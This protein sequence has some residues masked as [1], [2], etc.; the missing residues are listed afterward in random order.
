LYNSPTCKDIYDTKVPYDPEGKRKELSI[1]FNIL[2]LGLLG[3]LSGTLLC[4]LGVQAGHSF[5]YSTRVRRVCT[6]W[7]VS[8]LI[9]GFLGLLLSKGGH[10]ESWIPINK[11]MWSLS[12]I[13]ILSSLA[14][15]IL[16][17]L[18]LLVDVRKIFTG[19]PWIWLGMNSIVVFCGHEICGGRFP[20]EFQVN[21][22]H[23][24]KLA[25][26]VYGVMWWFFIAG[27]MYYKKIFI[28]I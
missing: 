2:F 19:A 4:Y 14:F 25:L 27:I 1:R 23:A 8:G 6:Q 9:C 5:V 18:Y 16:T 28:A 3:I 7:I 11:N 24:D 20:I 22:T 10:S 15:I 13:F 17:I 26:H 21:N 12:F